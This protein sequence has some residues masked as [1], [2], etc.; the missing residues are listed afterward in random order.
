M[1]VD[2]PMPVDEFVYDELFVFWGQEIVPFS[3]IETDLYEK[4]EVG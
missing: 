3:E 2:V 1:G 4:L